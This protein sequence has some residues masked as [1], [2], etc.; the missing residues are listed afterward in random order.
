MFKT[1][2]PDNAYGSFLSLA[3]SKA[4]SSRLRRGIS[5]NLQDQHLGERIISDDY[6]T[7]I[8]PRSMRRVVNSITVSGNRSIWMSIMQFLIYDSKNRS[9]DARF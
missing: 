9:F 8:N 3:D 4:G 2:R 6:F 5:Q 1:L 7:N